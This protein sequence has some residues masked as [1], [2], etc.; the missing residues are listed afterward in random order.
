MPQVNRLLDPRH[1][2]K[3][4][5][6]EAAFLS[7]GKRL[8]ISLAIAIRAPKKNR[9]PIGPRSNNDKRRMAGD[10]LAIHPP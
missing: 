5:A 8:N 3:L 6:M 2:S 9:G 4:E 10:G 1:S 7:L